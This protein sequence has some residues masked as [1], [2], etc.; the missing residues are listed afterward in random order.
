MSRL[1]KSLDQDPQEL[2]SGWE[3]QGD[4]FNF[5]EIASATY[6]IFALIRQTRQ[7]TVNADFS[8]TKLFYEES[9]WFFPPLVCLCCPNA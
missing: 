8:P 6:C 2:I 3:P 9:S 5:Q 1:N 7:Y 4:F